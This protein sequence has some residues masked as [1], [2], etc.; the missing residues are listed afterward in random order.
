MSSAV[1][2]QPLLA[3]QLVR[4]LARQPGGV[5]QTRKTPHQTAAEVHKG[6]TVF[7]QSSALLGGGLAG[8]MLTHLG[9]P[10]AP[11]AGLGMP[12]SNTC[13]AG[14]NSCFS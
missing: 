7:L 11:P 2:G 14:P 6:G 9:F 13:G 1:K 10:A 4:L 8:L 12:E 3:W 5:R